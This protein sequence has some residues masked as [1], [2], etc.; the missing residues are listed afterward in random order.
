[1][2]KIIFILLAV[3][4]LTSSNIVVYGQETT[5]LIERSDFLNEY[6]VKMQT[7][8]DLRVKTEA[9]RKQNNEIVKQ[10]K[11]LINDSNRIS[12]ENKVGQIKA[13]HQESKDLLDQAKTY[14]TQRTDIRKQWQN[15][16]KER[17]TEKATTNK[18]QITEITKKIEDIR[19]KIK[20]NN[21][22]I[23][24]L[25]NEVKIYRDANKEKIEQAKVLISKVTTMQNKIASER[26]VKNT[27]WQDFSNEVKGK[28]YAQALT[29]MDS[30]ISEKQVILADIEEKNLTLNEILAMQKS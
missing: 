12:V 24:P 18:D 26:I 30:I 22:L 17:D 2:K 10:I 15:A 27:L 19:I 9:A 13:I 28:K 7:I 14:A 11:N 1:M 4:F 3:I 6:L 23:K 21:E 20:S 5:Q 16:L 8:V 29:V 25:I